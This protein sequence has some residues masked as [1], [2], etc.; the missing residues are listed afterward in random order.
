MRARNA[1]RRAALRLLSLS[2]SCGAAHAAAPQPVWS[3]PAPNVIPTATPIPL[4][5]VPVLRA[6][7]GAEPG[8][9]TYTV[10]SGDTLSGIA[11]AHGTSVAELQRLNALRGVEI[12][13]GQ[14]LRLPAAPVTDA[15]RP[16]TYT[17]Q[18][19]D[20][21]SGI[22][23][24]HGTSVPELQRLNALSGAD[25]ARGQTLRLRADPAAREAGGADPT[26]D[27]TASYTV[28]AGDT[29]AVIA[30]RLNTT[31]QVLTSLNALRGT[32]IY[33]GQT[34]RVPALSSV[35]VTLTPPPSAA[36]T[37]SGGSAA[38]PAAPT[39]AAAAP[40]AGAVQTS[41][42]SATPP[43]T[44]DPCGPLDCAL[45]VSAAG[46]RTYSVSGRPELS[47]EFR[48]AAK[49]VPASLKVTWKRD[50]LV[51]ADVTIVP[52]LMR[53]LLGDSGVNNLGEGA[54]RVPNWLL[55]ECG[56]GAPKTSAR[57]RLGLDPAPSVLCARGMRAGTPVISL[58]ISR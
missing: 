36:P 39:A 5:D 57:Y 19:G 23:L 37:G 51:P 3:S 30:T 4:K 40:T 34:L 27:R 13:R 42:A 11:A 32:V 33:A 22:A 41:G 49:G 18:S 17:V 21:L 10:Q 58:V 16:S 28:R 46:T 54:W 8:G 6:A 53:A 43:R 52:E 12:T 14:T 50:A 55:A 2:L 1:A 48:D 56:R 26:P 38:K 31:P 24:A 25:I 9:A 45:T 15:P 29:L 47:L 20:T 35:T 7:P 44:P